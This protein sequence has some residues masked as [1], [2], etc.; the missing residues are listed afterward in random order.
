MAPPT[1]TAISK[2]A[3]R[4]TVFNFYQIHKDKGPLYTIKHF[5]G[6]YSRGYLYRLLKTFDKRKT[7]ERKKGTGTKGKKLSKKDVNPEGCGGGS[8]CP[9]GFL[10]GCHF[11]QDHAMVTK[12]LDFINKHPK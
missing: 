8:K 3:L 10:I 4:S 1:S 2:K 11:S 6:Q 9:Y 12:I 5:E 7:D